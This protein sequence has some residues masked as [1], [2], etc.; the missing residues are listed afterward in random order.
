MAI[1]AGTPAG[2][3][4]GT[5]DVSAGL[6]AISACLSVADV[7]RSARWYGDLLG[8]A[9]TDDATLEAAGARVAYL[10]GGDLRIELVQTAGSV[11][12]PQRPDPPAHTAVRGITQLT[13]YVRDLD[14]V[15][16]RC[17]RAG[18][19][20]AMAPVRAP[21]LHVAAFFVRDPDGNLLEFLERTDLD[22]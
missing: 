11:A 7:D 12:G 8:V 14:A 6:L 22:R 2:T 4:D 19:P 1:P 15:L 16:A 5:A 10:A 20:I 13:V 9:V 3:A 21:Q 18:I 17:E